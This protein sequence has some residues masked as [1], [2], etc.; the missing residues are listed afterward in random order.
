MSLFSI[1]IENFQSHEKTRLKLHQG[2]NA[3]VGDSDCGKSAVMRALLWCI[4]N[5]PQG[6]AHVSNWA[7][8]KKGDIKERCEVCVSASGGVVTRT[9]SK[10][11]NG[12]TLDDGSQDARKFSALRTDV[13]AEVADAL[14]I[15]PVNIQR[16]LD[17]PFLISATPGEAARYINSLV[18]L[19]VIDEALSIVN[20]MNRDTANEL[21][22]SQAAQEKRQ[23]EL[24]ALDWVE[25]LQT[26]ARQAED[27]EHKRDEL[28]AKATDM[29][30]DLK[31]WESASRRAAML[32]ADLMEIA[33]RLDQVDRISDRL[34]RAIATHNRVSQSYSEY[35]AEKKRSAGLEAV[36]RAGGLLDRAAQL[37]AQV[38]HKT[39]QRDAL[40]G[41]LED[42]DAAARYLLIDA[43]RLEDLLVVLNRTGAAIVEGRRVLE[44]NGLK[45][46]DR[47]APVAA[48]DLGAVEGKLSRLNRIRSTLQGCREDLE[49]KRADLV[50]YGTAAVILENARQGLD[51][52]LASLDGQICPC[53]GR[54]MHACEM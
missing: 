22:F 43:D 46:Y 32:E 26:L 27:L 2:I 12:Y 3:L 48:L 25:T 11:E 36:E 49:Q 29:I 16:Q 41:A 6:V 10:D 7:K 20:G 31:A 15:G 52:A 44:D 45:E 51:A 35:V 24:D 23:A 28:H 17:P 4:T 21:K 42:Y 30:V 47:A 38:A 50:N 14:N 5:A 54:P 18:D 39:D 34:D 13:P 37:E 53:C 1:T 40:V 33:N 8:N 9:R 19:Q